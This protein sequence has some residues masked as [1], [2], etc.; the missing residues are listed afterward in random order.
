MLFVQ[1]EVADRT[2]RMLT[3]AIEALDMGDPFDYATDIG[4]VI[5]EAAQDNLEAHKVRMQRE[6]ASSSISSCPRH[7]RAGTYVTPA[8][9]E[10]ERMSV[11]EREVFGPILHVVRFGARAH[12]Q[13]RRGDQCLGLSA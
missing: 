2:I 1:E 11:L 3:G 13:G 4:P 8:A 5:D 6:A 9:Y 7:C 10:I 12:R